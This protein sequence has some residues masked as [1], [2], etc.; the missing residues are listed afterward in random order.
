[1]RKKGMSRRAK[2]LA[3]L[4]AGGTARAGGYAVKK[5]YDRGVNPE[6]AYGRDAGNKFGVHAIGRGMRR[7]AQDFGLMKKPEGAIDRLKEYAGDLKQSPEMRAQLWDK[8]QRAVGAVTPHVGTAVKYGSFGV[9]TGLGYALTTQAGQN[10]IGKARDVYN[11]GQEMYNRGKKV[12]EDVKN[13][14]TMLKGELD[15]V[16]RTGVRRYLLGF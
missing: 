12:Y 10:L 15:N 14:G 8:T 5:A 9:G 2:L 6:Y 4:A 11:K 13:T 1:M 16:R 3:G 7:Y